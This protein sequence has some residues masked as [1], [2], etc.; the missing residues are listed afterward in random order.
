MV[1]AVVIGAA[2]RMG[3][4][5]IRVILDRKDIVCIGGVE[6][7]DHP[8]IGKDLG[9]ILGIGEL[10][11]RLWGSLDPL[12]EEAQVLIDFTSPEA[13]LHHLELASSFRKPMVIGT[14]GFTQEQ[15][16]R[17]KQLA[18]YIPCV[19]SPNMSLGVNLLFKLVEL[20][21]KVLGRDYDVEI[22]EF[23][24]RL[25]KDAPSGTALKLSQKIADVL[26][27]NLEEKAVFGRKGLTGPRTEGEI[28]ILSLRG[29]D[30]V[31]EHTVI[32][33]TEGERLELTHKASSRMTFAKGAVRAALWVVG[34]P[35]GLYD[36]EDVLE[37]KKPLF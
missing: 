5:I 6:R 27:L 31:G 15:F 34:K 25:K 17:I 28:G 14:T 19:L 26:G 37:F 32:F 11:A 3:Q 9:Q 4:S 29:G 24:H 30:V 21:A 7:K 1:K 23:H 8:L 20:V 2:G 22:I 35:P 13:T 36:M 18:K 12:L 10:G 33:A 16:E